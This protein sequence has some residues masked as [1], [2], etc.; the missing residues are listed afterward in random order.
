MSTWRVINDFPNY[1]VSDEWTKLRIYITNRILKTRPDK[2]G[3][4]IVD[5]SERGSTL[6]K[7]V[8]RLVAEA[9]IRNPQHLP[10]VDH[11]NNIR[12]DNRIEN[13]RW[14]TGSQNNFNRSNTKGYCFR[15]DINKYSGTNTVRWE[16]KLTWVIT[17]P[18]LKRVLLI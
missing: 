18:K 17:K 16:E 14:V 8:H 7:K 15:K 12:D 13:L 3:Y 2:D 5:F 11:I 6:T 10:Q 9:F 4:T 1:E